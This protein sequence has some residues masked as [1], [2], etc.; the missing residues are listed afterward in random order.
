MAGNVA[1][2]VLDVYRPLTFE[3]MADYAPFR[4]NVFTTKVTD[5]E[6]F[7]APK[8]S[9]GRIKY[10]EVTTEESKDRFNYRSANQINY[11][12]GDYQ[13]TINPD[14]SSVPADSVNTTNMMY[15]YAKTSLV[16]DKSRV[17]KGGSWRDP[18]YYLSPATRRYLDQNLSTNY[19][20]FRCAMGKVGGAYS[21]SKGK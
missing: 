2:W 18:A 16:S 9:L 5:E 17:Y 11:L 8:D 12:D 7:L 19:I 3:D 1:E 21:T 4:G 14:W 10:R 20:G 15:E 13:S 6:G